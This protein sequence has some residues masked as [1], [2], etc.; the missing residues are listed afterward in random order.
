MKKK[1]KPTRPLPGP[2]TIMGSVVRVARQQNRII[3]PMVARRFPGTAFA[4][5]VRSGNCHRVS[6]YLHEARTEGW[7]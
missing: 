4:K 3:G 7:L 2:D 1:L 6:W 5:Q